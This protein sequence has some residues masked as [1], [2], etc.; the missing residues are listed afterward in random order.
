MTLTPDLASSLNLAQG[1]LRG[2]G[3]AGPRIPMVFTCSEWRRKGISPLALRVNPH[4]VTFKQGKRTT[5]KDTQGGTAFFHWTDET[6]RNNDVLELDLRGRTGN[7]K[8]KPSPNAADQLVTQAVQKVASWLSQVPEGSVSDNPG[9]AKHYNWARLYELTREVMI[10]PRTGDK[11]LF[12]LLYCSP[13]FPARVM[14][15]GFF[16][17]VL[18]FTESAESPHML[19][20]G[21]SFTVQ[22]CD[23]SLD[24]LARYLTTALA[25][26]AALEQLIADNL[27]NT[28]ILLANEQ[29]SLSANSKQG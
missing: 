6:G 21:L 19:E 4:Q 18:D 11:N 2:N 26:P 15:T 17:K 28:G 10:N 7:I 12:Q 1:F 29:N 3:Q 25:S 24:I 14:F 23:P 13:V 22:R 8:N 20:Y 5:R 27:K 16:S 9:A